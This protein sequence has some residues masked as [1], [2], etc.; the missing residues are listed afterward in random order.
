MRLLVIRHAEQEFPRAPAF[1]DPPLSATGRRQARR[2]A[3][4]LRERILSRVVSSNMVRA[5]ETARPIVSSLRVPLVVEPQLAEISMGDLA[6]WSAAEQPEWDRLT[7]CWAEGDLACACPG[8]ESLADVIERVGPVATRLVAEADGHDFA[9]IAHA[10]V[11]GVVLSMLCPALRP[12]LGK[13]I[14][15]SHTGIWELVGKGDNFEVMRRNDT[16]HLE[17]PVL[18]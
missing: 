13:D 11:N 10:V 9:I 16:G 1:E 7:A 14:G 4:A 12:M 8:G 2:L 17:V 3:Y 5:L 6:A 18:P 15:H